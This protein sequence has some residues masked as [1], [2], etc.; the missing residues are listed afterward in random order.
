MALRRLCKKNKT[1][2]HQHRIILQYWTRSYT[3]RRQAVD[4]D[5]ATEKSLLG[6]EVHEVM[7]NYEGMRE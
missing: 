3:L 6:E 2:L 1:S 4:T 5:E 7:L